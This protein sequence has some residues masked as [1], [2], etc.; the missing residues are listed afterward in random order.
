MIGDAMCFPGLD[1]TAHPPPR[2]VQGPGVILL[3]R[4]IGEVTNTKLRV[5]AGRLTEGG[6]PGP[7]AGARSRFRITGMIPV[8]S[9]RFRTAC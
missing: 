1:D 8:V 9:H 7:G 4:S 3:C 2:P 5:S 6:L